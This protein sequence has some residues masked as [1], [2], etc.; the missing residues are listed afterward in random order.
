LKLSV[1]VNYPWAWNKF[2]VYFGS[3]E[4]VPGDRREYDV[5]L[6]NL[7]RNLDRLAGAGASVVRIF[8]LCNAANL[9][10]TRDGQG[11]LAPISMSIPVSADGPPPRFEPVAPWRSFVPPAKTSS[12]Y[13]DQLG[14][15]LRAFVRR[16][17][18]VIPC[19]TSF[20]AFA[21]GP[22]SSCRTDI[23]IDPGARA[24]FL[25][26]VVDPFLQVA[27]QDGNERAVLAWDI[28]NEPGQVTESMYV[29]YLRKTTYPIPRWQMAGFLREV[30][31]RIE[32]KGFATTV[33][34]HHAGDF[35]L[36]TGS[37]PQF[38]YY[39][40]D[41][42]REAGVR[43]FFVPSRLPPHRETLA[44]VGELQSAYRQRDQAGSVPWPEIPESVQ[45]G[46]SEFEG[47]SEGTV[48]RL[49]LLEEKGY[50]L[51]LLWPD[52]DDVTYPE[53]PE[54]ELHFTDAV[55]RGIEAYA[56]G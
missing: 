44:F 20:E 3:G 19:L 18:R 53:H 29:S 23:V 11:P 37:L 52:R 5:W 48:A 54:D 14:A 40:Q 46:T 10:S 49:R 16:E 6:Q 35:D 2:G 36:P 43:R 27:S 38:H 22:R 55:L 50:G 41:T 45:R 34:H 31:A 26:G 9:G 12:I 15:M 28:V 51:A 13:I 56:R 1:G 24:W 4:T 42:S 32:K 39:P 7:E 25:E 33:G 17:M 21:Q 47:T 8:L 30:I